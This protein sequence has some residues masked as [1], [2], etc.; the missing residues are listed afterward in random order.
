MINRLR[1]IKNYL[2]FGGVACWGLLLVSCMMVDRT[3]FAPPHIPGAANAT[4]VGSK[5][6]QQCHENITSGFH[7]ATHAKLMAPGDNAKNVG[8]ETCHG[9]GSVHSK[10]GG[11]A[12]TILNPQLSPETC[13]QCHMDKRGEFQLPSAHPI[14]HGKMSCSDCHDP[15]KGDAVMGGKTN[16]AA[17]NDTCLKCHSAQSGPYVF[18]HEAM[19][20]GCMT[21]HSAH[22][23]VNDKMLKAR[24]QTLCL[25]CHYQQQTVSGQL[26]IGGRDHAA[27]VQRGTC[28]TAGCHEAVHGSH[29]NSSLRF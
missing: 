9:P 13:Y 17:L 5:D 7:D 12:G 19:R 27:F 20:E 3:M 15:H 24:N 21:C 4:F 14:A 29:V 10:T 22:G 25:Q 2:I 16:L 6:C 26:L 28:W 23:S 1:S 11:G 18:E 8:C